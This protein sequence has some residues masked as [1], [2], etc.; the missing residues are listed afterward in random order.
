MSLLFQICCIYKKI[1]HIMVM[2]LF[3]LYY[4]N[5]KETV[6]RTSNKI[7]EES[8]LS[9]A[10]QIKSKKL[11]ST[12]VVEAFIERIKLVNPIIN[13]MVD[14][15]FNE[16]L[17]EAKEIDEKLKLNIYTPKELEDLIYLGVPFTT[18]ESVLCKDLSATFGLIARKGIKADKDA[19]VIAL[20][21]SSGAILLGV[22]NVPEIN[23]WMETYNK[24]YGRTKNPYDTTRNV[25]GSTGGD[26][27][28][29]AALGTPISIGTDLAGSIRAPA[30]RCGIF[31]HKPS[32]DVI[33]TKGLT[34]RSGNEG[35]TLVTSGPMAKKSEDLLPMLKIITKNDFRLK[36]N[37]EID[38]TKIKIFYSTSI[39]CFKNGPIGNDCLKAVEKAA[40]YF[41]GYSVKKPEKIRFNGLNNG[42]DLW[43]YSK[44]KENWRY[45]EEIKNNLEKTN[46]KREFKK[47]LVGKCDHSLYTL[48]VLLRLATYKPYNEEIMEKLIQ[49]AREE[50]I[51]LLGDDGVLILPS[52]PYP[53]K[54]H[55]TMILEPLFRLGLITKGFLLG[56]KSLVDALMIGCVL[57]WL[58]S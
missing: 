15:R 51:E 37:Q 7:L 56:F 20:M 38:V 19:D 53:A 55:N 11:N 17:D 33:S 26:A 18:K 42:P 48:Y 24:V 12:A 35:P 23:M 31:G 32:N 43:F 57:L 44:V 1:Y 4:K 10:R 22:C 5:K 9:L 29:L 36:L 46:F 16:A 2:F 45:E 34:F 41:D 49:D 50:I 58:V 54:Y 14:Q 13:A 27:A 8:A 47:Y 3:S 30:F 39:E 28:L 52:E 40:K 6:P 21:K 25:G